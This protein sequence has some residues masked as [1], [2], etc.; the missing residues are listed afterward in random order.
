MAIPGLVYSVYVQQGNRQVY[1]SYDLTAGATSYSIQRSLDGV[2]FTTLATPAANTYIDAAVT[3]GVLYYYQVAATNISG[4]GPYSTPQKIVVAPASEMSLLQLRTMV[5]QRADRVGSNFVTLPEYNNFINQ[6]MY[7][8]YDLLITI[9]EEY[10]VADPI[11]FPAQPNQSVYPLP[12]GLLTFTNGNTQQANFVAP[13]FYKFKGQDLA[14]NTAQNAFVTINKFTF[15]DRNTFVYPNTASTIYGVFNLQYRLQGNNIKFIPTPSS[16]QLLQMWYIPRLPQLVADTDI[17]TIG[18]SGWLQYVIV[19]A[20]K[21]ALDKEESDTSKLDAELLFLKTRIEETSAN[22]DTGQP[23][24]VSD[25]RQNGEWGSM[26]GGYGW[27]G[28][29]GGY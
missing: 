22:R 8:L 20:A 5:Q 27:S 16:N 7:E 26:N 21:Y 12:D 13:P 17:T 18:I 3:T 6:S 14:L 2:T 19:R 24:R 4:T 15:M 25:V 28:P 1:L 10:F 23:D 9:D 29:L 11:I